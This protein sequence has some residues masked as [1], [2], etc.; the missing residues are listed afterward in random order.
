MQIE[1]ILKKTLNLGELQYH[2]MCGL[3]LGLGQDLHK[4]IGVNF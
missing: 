4:N 2:I 1:C 3:D